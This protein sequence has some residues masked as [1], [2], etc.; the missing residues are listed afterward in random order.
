M[1]ADRG[2][3]DAAANLRAAD[4]LDGRTTHRDD[5]LAARR[6]ASRH[7]VEAVRRGCPRPAES[8]GGLRAVASRRDPR[9]YAAVSTDPGRGPIRR[10]HRAVA[11]TRCDRDPTRR[12]DRCGAAATNLGRDPLRDDRCR[13]ALPRAHLDCAARAAD[14]QA[15]PRARASDRHAAV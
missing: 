2:F 3:P 1:A 14:H 15:S 7:F 8:R 11:S 9:R 4:R 6:L 13:A 10:D 5:R 12:H